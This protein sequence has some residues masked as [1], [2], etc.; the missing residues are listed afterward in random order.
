MNPMSNHHPLGDANAYHLTSFLVNVMFLFLV[1]TV[2]LTPGLYKLW[3]SYLL[4]LYSRGMSKIHAKCV[5]KIAF[6]EEI[7]D[8]INARLI[9]DFVNLPFYMYDY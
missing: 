3:N 8:S 1:N 6:M 9:L 5:L 2:N 7:E 4:F